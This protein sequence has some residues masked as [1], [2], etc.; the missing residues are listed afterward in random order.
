MAKKMAVASSLCN[1]ARDEEE[2]ERVVT[3]IQETL[4][5]LGVTREKALATLEQTRP[6]TFARLYPHYQ[7]PKPAR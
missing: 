3:R 5:E 4:E 2:I 7:R 1:S 6:Q